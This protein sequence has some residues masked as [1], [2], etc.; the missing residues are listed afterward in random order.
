M[1]IARL[2]IA[3]WIASAAVACSGQRTKPAEK[4]LPLHA[5][6]LPM[7]PVTLS[8]EQQF[9]YMR[10]H[11]WD[12][13]RFADTLALREVDTMQMLRRYGYYIA[14]LSERPNDR[15]P[16]DTLMRRAASSRPMLDLFLYLAEAVLHDPNSPLR[17]DELYIPVLEAQ[18]ATSYYDEYE[19]I[20][21]LYDLELA[22]KNRLGEPANDF[23]YTLAD[24]RTGTLHKIEAE[25]LLLFFNNPDCPMCKEISQAIQNSALLQQRL[26][27]GSLKILAL[28]PDEDLQAWRNY[29]REIPAA[30]I[31][32]YDAGCQLRE[33][34]LY[35]LNA[36]PS[37][38]L[39]DREKRVLIK[40]ATEVTLIEA[41]IGR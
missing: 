37:L 8:E 32:A 25:Y 21:P 40:D 35:A 24:G 39:L 22:R 20:A 5:F 17:N 2:I 18:L 19:R 31:N 1:R 13:F 4:A 3:L 10:Q 33:Q 7:P 28:Y 34:E 6:T 38:Y 30:W 15:R 29:R 11:Y 14:L 16:I 41:A 23:R 12:R 27:D 9:E 36:I 26:A